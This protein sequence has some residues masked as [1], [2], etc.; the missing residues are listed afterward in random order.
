V[1]TSASPPSAWWLR[2]CHRPLL[3]NMTSDNDELGPEAQAVAALS[4]IAVILQSSTHP[5]HKM[6]GVATIAAMFGDMLY[7]DVIPVPGGP[8]RHAAFTVAAPI[9][10]ATSSDAAGP[11][12]SSSSATTAASMT[13][14]SPTGAAPVTKASTEI[15][16]K[17]RPAK[18]PRGPTPPPPPRHE[19]CE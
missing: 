15:T 14:T 8:Q 2:S 7:H 5:V 9:A 3:H 11:M 10:G 18:K 1:A 12:A 6:R 13:S 17:A 16:P 4:Y 19:S